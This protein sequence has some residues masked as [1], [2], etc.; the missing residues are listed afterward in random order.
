MGA[1][2]RA[3][4]VLG[5]ERGSV[6]TF[7]LILLP[8]LVA[9]IGLSFDGA[10]ILA[11]R[12]E[13]L[14]NAQNA[15]VAGT[16]GLDE[17]ATRQGNTSLDPSLV[18]VEVNSYLSLVGATGS[19]TTTAETVTVTVTDTVDME[20]LSILGINQKTVSGTATARVVRGVEGPDT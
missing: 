4:H 7:W 12:R 8:I 6:M 13:A 19:H 1:L 5:D 14:D 16:Q 3:W 9:T 10:Q 20:M 2:Q 17:T 11:A 15:A 18:A